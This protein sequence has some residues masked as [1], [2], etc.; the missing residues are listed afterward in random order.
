[1]AT[2][3]PTT[4]I[5]IKS[6]SISNVLPG[7]RHKER[8]KGA[9]KG[10][11]RVDGPED[12]EADDE[13][14]RNDGQLSGRRWSCSSCVNAERKVWIVLFSFRQRFFS[15]CTSDEADVVRLIFIPSSAAASTSASDDNRHLLH[16]IASH[17]RPNHVLSTLL[18]KN[19]EG[20]MKTDTWF[21]LCPVR[22]MR[23]V[24]TWTIGNRYSCMYACIGPQ[25]TQ[26][27][28]S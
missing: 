16:S 8:W 12:E 18:W 9:T 23:C 13:R 17:F 5:S 19:R 22:Y 2:P 21:S 25:R 20:E 14:R 27:T 6:H 28:F 10:Q 26:H 24:I 1:M 15:Q 7:T 4:N 3:F 11:I